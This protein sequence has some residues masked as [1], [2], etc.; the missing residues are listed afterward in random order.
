[1]KCVGY[2]KQF[3]QYHEEFNFIHVPTSGYK[4]KN[5]VSAVKVSATHF[6]RQLVF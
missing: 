6:E 5:F 3:I 2:I 1:M 4:Y